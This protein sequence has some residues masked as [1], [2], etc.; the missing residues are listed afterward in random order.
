MRNTSLVK[1]AHILGAAAYLV[2]TAVFAAAAAGADEGRVVRVTARQFEFEPDTIVLKRG[3]PVTIVL[4]SLDR[5]HG[6]KVPAFDV[7]LDALPGETTRVTFVPDKAGRF[8]WLCD[9][10]C[11]VDHEGMSGLFVVEE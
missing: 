7:R 10:F 9:V 6:F 8:S 11:G 2:C 5:P 4:T 1:H 3:E